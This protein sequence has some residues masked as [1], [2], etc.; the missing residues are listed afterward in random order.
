[1]MM[2]WPRLLVLLPHEAGPR[3]GAGAEVRPCLR[4]HG[5]SENVWRESGAVCARAV[6]GWTDSGGPLRPSH[7]LVR[8]YGRLIGSFHREEVSQ[9]VPDRAK[10][11][12]GHGRP[13]PDMRTF[14]IGYQ[15]T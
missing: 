8:S 1:M 9:G 3:G 6:P 5:H 13:A 15:W 12:V 7:A 2:R 4:R 10:L 14:S 11:A